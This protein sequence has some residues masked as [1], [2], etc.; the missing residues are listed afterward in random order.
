M[1]E[2]ADDRISANESPMTE[3]KSGR[4][5][6]FTHNLNHDSATI[7]ECRSSPRQK[8]RT[9]TGSLHTVLSG[10][11]LPNQADAAAGSG[12]V[13]PEFCMILPA[14]QPGFRSDPT[15]KA[16]HS[17]NQTGESLE[18]HANIR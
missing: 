18:E 1:I 17:V 4:P 14:R 16:E 12:R 9:K 10:H 11:C 7:S 6:F 2:R 13:S 8:I 3:D 5:N 15:A